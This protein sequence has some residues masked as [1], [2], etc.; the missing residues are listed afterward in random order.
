MKKSMQ[1][2]IQKICEATK[3]EFHYREE[4]L[5][6]HTNKKWVSSKSHHKQFSFGKITWILF[7]I[8]IAS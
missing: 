6:L 7:V 8:T 4:L 5:Y 2:D 3:G 1:N